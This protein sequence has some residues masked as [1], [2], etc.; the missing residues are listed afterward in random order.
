MLGIN[1]KKRLRPLFVFFGPMELTILMP[2]LNEART[3]P[4]CIGNASA[5]LE[6]YGVSIPKFW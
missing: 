2:C 4:A 3:L 1:L 5:F 6:R